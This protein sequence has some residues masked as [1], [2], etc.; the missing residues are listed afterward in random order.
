MP[1]DAQRR[2]TLKWQEKT[3][4]IRFRVPKGSKELYAA[5]AKAR[6]ESLTA[7]LNRAAKE[8]MEKDMN[9]A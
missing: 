3:D 2:A 7:F 8:T 5:H 4:E 1:T 9:R 6:G